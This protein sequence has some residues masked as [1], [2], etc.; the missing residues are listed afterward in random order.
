MNERSRKFL[1]AAEDELQ[2]K[3][4]YKKKYKSGNVGRLSLGTPHHLSD[5]DFDNTMGNPYRD[6]A[7]YVAAKDYADGGRLS[8]VGPDHSSYH[9]DHAYKLY[10][11]ENSSWGYR[12]GEYLPK[13]DIYKGDKAFEKAIDDADFEI[14]NYNDDNYEYEKGGR[15]WH[16]K[17]DVD[18]SI[19]RVIRNVLR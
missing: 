18:E 9:K 5:A 7:Y 14:D 17:D 10:P 13:S 8:D 1:K 12:C 16:L 3:F 15:G 2:K 6:K 4:G 11:Y 19:R